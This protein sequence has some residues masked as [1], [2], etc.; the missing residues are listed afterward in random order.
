MTTTTTINHQGKAADWLAREYNFFTFLPLEKAPKE[1]R[2]IYQLFE[3]YN[4]LLGEQL[5]PAEL[6]SKFIKIKK[7]LKILKQGNLRFFN[8]EQAKHPLPYAIKIGDED[9]ALSSLN[10]IQDVN[11]S[12]N[13]KTPLQLA[14]KYN[15]VNVALK[16]INHPDCDINAVD[17]NENTA[18]HAAISLKESKAAINIIHLLLK[19]GADPNQFNN[20][21]DS[22][23][24]VA[25]LSGNKELVAPFINSSLKLNQKTSTTTLVHLLVESIDNKEMLTYILKWDRSAI[26]SLN[27]E[28]KTPLHLAIQLGNAS[29]AALLIEYGADVNLPTGGETPFYLAAQSGSLEMLYLL[30]SRGALLSSSGKCSDIILTAIRSGKIEV[31]DFILTTYDCSEF[32]NTRHE[33]GH[34]LLIHAIHS[35]S[36]PMVALLIMHGAETSPKSTKISPLNYALLRGDLE[37]FKLLLLNQ[38]IPAFD[39]ILS[40][41]LKLL[42]HTESAPFPPCGFTPLH[43]AIVSQN[44]EMVTHFLKGECDVNAPAEIIKGNTPLHLAVSLSKSDEGL[45]IIQILLNK[46]ADANKLNDHDQSPFHTSILLKKLPVAQTIIAA[47][48]DRILIQEMG[49]AYNKITI[50]HVAAAMGQFDPIL[51][52]LLQQ[53]RTRINELNYAGLSPLHCA[54]SQGQLSTI[55]LLIAYGADVNQK[56]DRLQMTSFELA[57]MNNT[58][59]A[60]DC[61]MQNHFDITPIN[62]HFE[63]IKLALDTNKL[64]VLDYVLQMGKFPVNIPDCPDESAALSHAVRYAAIPLIKSLID[65]GADP[66]YDNY[67]ALFLAFERGDLEIIKLLLPKETDHSLTIHGSTPVLRAVR[68]KKIEIVRYLVGLNYNLNAQSS[69]GFSPLHYAAKQG[70]FNIF[71]WLYKNG[72]SFFQKNP[73]GFTP[74]DYSETSNNPNIVSFIRKLMLNS[75]R[76]F[77][78]DLPNENSF[79]SLKDSR[80]K[81]VLRNKGRHITSKP[82]EVHLYSLCLEHLQTHLAINGSTTVSSKGAQ[83]IIEC[84]DPL[85]NEILS[86]I[87][88]AFGKDFSAE[89][90]ILILKN[91]TESNSKSKFATLQRIIKKEELQTDYQIQQNKEMRAFMAAFSHLKRFDFLETTISHPDLSILCKNEGLREKFL[92]PALKKIFTG[93]DLIINKDLITLKNGGKSQFEQ[94]QKKITSSQMEKFLPKKEMES[95]SSPKTNLVASPSTSQ[96]NAAAATKK[97]NEEREAKRERHQVN[98]QAKKP[99][100]SNHKASSSGKTSSSQKGKKKNSKISTPKKAKKLSKALSKKEQKKEERPLFEPYPPMA[101]NYHS[102]G[103]SSSNVSAGAPVEMVIHSNDAGI[104]LPK[105]ST[106]SEEPQIQSEKKAAIIHNPA[107]IRRLKFAKKN[108]GKIRK[109]YD[110]HKQWML[111]DL[112]TAHD[113]LIAHALGLHLMHALGALY[114]TPTDEQIGQEDFEQHIAEFVIEKDLARNIRN[115]LRHSYDKHSAA[116]VINFAQKL[117]EAGVEERIETLLSAEVQREG[118]SIS[119]VTVKSA[120]LCPMEGKEKATESEE[121][122]DKGKDVCPEQICRKIS[123]ELK[124]IDNFKANYGS[125]ETCPASIYR[126]A[127]KKCLSNISE[128]LN[129]LSKNRDDNIFKNTVLAKVRT[130]GN[131]FAHV[132]QRG[133]QSKISKRQLK[134]LI[135]NT[136]KMRSE[137]NE[138]W[139]ANSAS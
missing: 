72:A 59:A 111:N 122:E 6:D 88:K 34:S 70:P 46:G 77:P 26:N 82:Q 38:N 9:L 74:L 135:N 3:K 85:L 31:L 49:G 61:L 83:I 15:M 52:F 30:T 35:G 19:K 22:P 137:L 136:K 125:S 129:A 54:L 112:D 91:I 62:G 110:L 58:P 100:G 121:G 118:L 24:F 128:C 120:S 50:L 126:A 114:R 68:T 25:A 107:D 106:A 5:V 18:L 84:K 16:I 131:H 57:L 47:Y 102:L 55:Q 90:D 65:H 63:I 127:Q 66:A 2:R 29:L 32:I 116:D 36:V 89:G 80:E 117:L 97:T 11:Q 14:I 132:E 44:L 45:Q 28:G 139:K 27:A 60:M 86:N 92:I 42:K 1:Y 75:S 101:P 98:Q 113:L 134:L 123:G 133:G 124:K 8:R 119:Y 99:L 12:L 43:L 138:I 95:S 48:R 93:D 23:F 53:D 56:D 41:R 67:D 71:V 108:I 13:G 17:V 109:F 20:L 73:T 39:P 10:T 105:K 7:E 33:K 4:Y 40:G 76:F 81:I 115:Q 37:I 104:P 130:W 69:S 96:Q 87:F 94:I 51:D 21:G 78:H 64:E 79:H 103:N